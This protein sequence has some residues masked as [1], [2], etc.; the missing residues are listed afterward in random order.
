MNVYYMTYCIYLYSMICLRVTPLA[1]I[2]L[3]SMGTKKRK[4]QPLVAPV[5]SMKRARH[6]TSSFHKLTQ[7]VTYV[8]TGRLRTHNVQAPRQQVGVLSPD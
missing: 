1:Q 7:Q 5:K 4:P 6:L 2:V 8:H 3:L